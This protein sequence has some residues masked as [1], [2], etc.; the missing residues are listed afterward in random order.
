MLKRVRIKGYKSLID[1]DVQLQPLTVI[2]GPNASGKS[3]FLDALQLLSRLVSSRKL[4]EAFD[5]PYR[6]KPLESFSFPTTGI[7]GL[8]EQESASFV[9]EVDFEVSQS[10]V[11][12]VSQQIR[13]M[14]RVPNGKATPKSPEGEAERLPIRERNLRY[15]VEI[16]ILPK[17]GT[18]RVVDEFLAALNKKGELN[19][20]RNPFLERMD[21]HISLRME[22]QAHPSYI[23][24]YLDHT[25]LST[26][27]YA[28]N[29]PHLTAARLELE[30]WNFFYFEP[31][32]RMRA[33]NPVK[34]VRHIGLMGEELAA[35]LNTLKVVDEKQFRAVEKSLNAIVPSI[36]AID[37]EVN[38]FG[39]V[40]LRLIENGIAIPARVVSEGSLRIL[41]L[42]ALQG[43]KENASLIGFEEPENG[44][45]P[46]RIELVAELLKA[47]S[48][49]RT[50]FIVTTHSH[51]LTEL[52]EDTSLLVCR[53]DEGGTSLVPFT[54]LPM[55]RAKAIGDSLN[56]E[57]QT[58]IG[59]RILRGDFDE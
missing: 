51:R 49:K 13:E 24:L 58:T 11:D 43:A 32:E 5:P 34:E 38:N 7:K 19:S 56:D 28:P 12:A 37:V 36:E 35:F 57:P 2:F 14:K 9:I 3:N 31:R 22:G 21:D 54:E 10:I 8:L 55:F 1:V 29:Y 25:I 59:E 20:N 39:E 53:K 23:D 4:T 30:S 41:G 18:L 45:H 40:E 27:P 50:Q 44:I 26:R 16:E 47:R 17:S 52:I 42:L 6:G 46:R 15:R 33:V 48:S